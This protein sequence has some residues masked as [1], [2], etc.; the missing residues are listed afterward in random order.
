MVASWEGGFVV[1]TEEVRHVT[2]SWIISKA[3]LHSQHKNE[4]DKDESVRI[5]FKYCHTEHTHLFTNR[6]YL[7]KRKKEKTSVQKLFH[8]KFYVNEV[9][10]LLK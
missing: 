1:F 9:P 8:S 7:K 6:F 10:A 5:H 2:M 3:S 4:L